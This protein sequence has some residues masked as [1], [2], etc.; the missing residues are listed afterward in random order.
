MSLPTEEWKMSEKAL[1][2]IEIDGR[3]VT[4]VVPTRDILRIINDAA[5][6]EGK[7]VMTFERYDDAPDRVGVPVKSFA[8]IGPTWDDVLARNEYELT[9]LDVKLVL[10]DTLV[11]GMEPWAWVGKEPITKG[12]KEGGV[13]IFNS[14]RKPEYLLKFMPKGKYKIATVD[15]E[16]IDKRLAAPLL[17]AMAKAA[18]DILS[19]E[20]L[21]ESIK[22]AYPGPEAEAKV[23]AFKR[24]M[25]AT[26]VMEVK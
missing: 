14:S 21:I 17:G 3:G 18:P 12:I 26:T 2:E 22:S 10:D 4:Q 23:E 19:Q 8:K 24:A 20:A 9:T 15:A 16:K 7:A 1:K 5:M 13:I 11:K 6:G 25:A